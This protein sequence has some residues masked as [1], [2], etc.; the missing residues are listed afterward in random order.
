MKT[1]IACSPLFSEMNII[2][3]GRCVPK[4]VVFYNGTS[5]MPDETI[6]RLSDSFPEDRRNESDIEVRVRMLNINH[7]RNISI[8]NKC[9]PWEEYSWF[10]EKIRK[11][12]R[13]RIQDAVD[14]ALNEMPDGFVIKQ[15]LMEHR[16]EVRGIIDTEYNEAEVMEGFKNEGRAEG[17]AAGLAEGHAA[18]LAEGHAAGLAE[19]HAAGL[20]EGETIKL[21]KQVYLKLRKNK[22]IEQIADELEESD[23]IT[24]IRVIVDLIRK[25]TPEL[26]LD[27]EELTQDVL[28]KLSI[29]P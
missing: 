5:D 21:I 19:G 28:E 14:R 13:I 7:G 29:M 11:Y 27:E 6:L 20:T 10:I 25:T 26:V 3:S 16:S 12:K 22:P 18:G 4:L 1:K 15:F 23:N 24:K 9:K 17:H 8:M 2:R